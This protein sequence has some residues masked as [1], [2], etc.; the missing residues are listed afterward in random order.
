MNIISGLFSS[1]VE[2]PHKIT[3]E[4]MQYAIKNTDLFTIINTLHKN[5]QICLINKTIPFNKEELLVNDLLENG[6]NRK[7]V[8]YGKNAS[9][10]SVDIKYKQLI[11]FGFKETYI[12]SGG[13][14]EWLLLQDIY[15]ENEFPTTSKEI[16][17]LKYRGKRVF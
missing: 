12:Y 4:D 2:K 14:F 8:I 1:S 11:S 7:F 3:F 6:E 5:E 13:L 17:L 9:D 15:G 16:D 10:L